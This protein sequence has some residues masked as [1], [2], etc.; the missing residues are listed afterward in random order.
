ME[1]VLNINVLQKIKQCDIVL[2]SNLNCNVQ[3]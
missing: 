2:F 3:A 1:F